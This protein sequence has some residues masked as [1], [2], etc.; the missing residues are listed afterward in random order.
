MEQLRSTTTA[1]SDNTA[2]TRQL[3]QEARDTVESAASTIDEL[4]RKVEGLSELDLKTRDTSAQLQ[5]LNALAEH[6]TSKF[7][8]LEHQQQTIEHALVES[9]R[10][11]EMVW[12]MDAQI[13][14]LNEGSAM[15]VRVEETVARLERLHRD[16]AAELQEALSIRQKL[17]DTF[18]T[19]RRDATELVQVVQRHVDHLAVNKNEL[20]TLSERLATAQSALAG[21]EH[22]LDH[23]STIDASVEGLSEKVEKISTRF[24]QLTAEA[25]VL[26]DKQATLGTLEQRLDQADAAAKRIG[27]QIDGLGERRKE[28]DILSARFAEFDEIH[29]RACALTDALRTD[30][31][32]LARFVEQTASF[33]QDAPGITG[34]IEALKTSVGEVEAIALKATSM[35]PKVHELSDNVERLTPRLQLI[36]QLQERLSELHQLSGEIDGKLATQLSRRA[37]LDSV[38][39]AC[40]GLSARLTDAQHAFTTLL[41]TQTKLTAIPEQISALEAAIREPHTAC[42]ACSRTRRRSRRRNVVSSPSTTRPSVLASD[43]AEHIDLLRGLQTELA[44]TAALK[45]QLCDE[46][47]QLQS[48]HRETLATTRETEHQL[49][50]LSASCLQIEERRANVARAERIVEALEHRISELEHASSSVDTKIEAIADRE[51]IV[52]TVKRQVETI[53][54]VAQRAQAELLAVADG[55]SHL[56]ESRVEV[57]RLLTDLADISAKTADV[58]ARGTVV[59]DVRRKAD[60]VVCLLDDIRVTLDTVSEQKAMIDHVAEHLV[61]LDDA[62]A[63]ARGTTKALQTE[64]KLAQRIVENVRTVHARAGGEVRKVG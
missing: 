15:A 38:Q 54:A 20:D 42:K 55:H 6:V 12:N 24:S 21:V 45:A 10:V 34:K 16:S 36:E 50:Q 44:N 56:A 26:D 53:H 13:V 35:A 25:Q 4:R 23:V 2:A 29:G 57:Q 60:A 27:W 22:R 7:K 49:Q 31:Q 40:D 5:T 18:E 48:M 1:L 51:R 59:N 64:R 46:L 32:Q 62:I 28:L 17:T 8:A 47:V 58:E 14:K 41:A 63:E 61:R 43:L 11:T 39:I 3:S 37:E 9:R 19:Q 52:E 33:M 30:K